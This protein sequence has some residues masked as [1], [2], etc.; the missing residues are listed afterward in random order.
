M[1]QLNDLIKL[2]QEKL[3]KGDRT[4]VM[5]SITMDAHGRDIVQKMIRNRVNTENSF[6]WQSQLKHMQEI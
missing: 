1:N 3:S 6:E 2:T 4:R 5:V